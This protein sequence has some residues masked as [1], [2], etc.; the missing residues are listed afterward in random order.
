MNHPSEWTKFY[1]TTRGAFRY[2][3]KGSGVVRDTLMAIGR[4]LG[5]TAKKA[6]TTAAKEAATKA[7]TA[8]AKKAS[9]KGSEKIQA[10]LRK[11]APSKLST[12]SKKKLQKIMKPSKLTDDSQKKLQKIMNSSKAAKRKVNQILAALD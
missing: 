1:D 6:A 2:K 3:H 12:D 4:R 5:L 11:R 10:I 8:V 7:A 9:E